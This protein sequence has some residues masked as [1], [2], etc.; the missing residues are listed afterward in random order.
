MTPVYLGTPV[1]FGHA[2]CATDFSLVNGVKT[3]CCRDSAGQ[4]SSPTGIRLITE[5]FLN[6]RCRG[7]MYF[8]GAKAITAPTAPVAAPFLVDMSYGQTSTEIARLQAFLAKLGYFTYPDNTGFYGEITRQAVLAFQQD[9][10]ANQSW[11]AYLVVMA[12]QGRHVSKMT[13]D[14]LN[15]LRT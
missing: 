15:L 2:V 9:H 11:W 14:A 8:L 6:K 4:F 7:A 10:V 3:L 13:R 12:N 1:T 5:D